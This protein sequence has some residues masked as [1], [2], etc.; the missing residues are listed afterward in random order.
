MISAFTYAVCNKGL[1]E[2]SIS[3]A[4]NSEIPETLFRNKAGYSIRA[5]SFADIPTAYSFRIRRQKP[6][7]E[8][9]MS[10]NAISCLILTIIYELCR[11]GKECEGFEPCGFIEPH[12]DIHIMHSLS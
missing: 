6:R 9:R 5:D 8:E 2:I 10:E 11:L 7:I 4:D 12:H 1:Q 3:S